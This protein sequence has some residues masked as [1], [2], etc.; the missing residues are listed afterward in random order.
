MCLAIP[1]KLIEISEDPYGVRMGRANFGGIVKQVCL[2]Y[3][4]DVQAGDYVL[5]HV[6]FAL[7]K[8]DEAEAERTY[9]AL[10]DLEQLDDLNVPEFAEDETYP[11]VEPRPPRPAVPS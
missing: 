11:P 9:Q 7:G 8:V 1:G 3:T 6:G 10:K 2:Q 4:P 5:V